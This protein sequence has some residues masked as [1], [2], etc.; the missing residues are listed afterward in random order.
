MNVQT[1]PIYCHSCH[2][3]SKPDLHVFQAWQP[4]ALVKTVKK[5][6]RRGQNISTA[7]DSM[8]TYNMPV[9]KMVL[10]IGDQFLL[11]TQG[12]VELKQISPFTRIPLC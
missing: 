8:N 9:G 11:I 1:T 7:N 12:S 10:S 3:A 4:Y 5:I 2:Q 6:Y